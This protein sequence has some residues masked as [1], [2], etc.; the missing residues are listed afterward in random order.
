MIDHSLVP[1]HPHPRDLSLAKPLWFNVYT[2]TFPF[3]A[4]TSFRP[5]EHLHHPFPQLTTL[6]K[7]ST[8]TDR[9]VTTPRAPPL[10]IT[11]TRSPPYLACI[12][13]VHSAQHIPFFLKSL[14]AAPLCA[15][16]GGHKVKRG[17][18]ISVPSGVLCRED[19]IVGRC[20]QSSYRP[21]GRLYTRG[22]HCYHHHPRSQQTSRKEQAILHNDSCKDQMYVA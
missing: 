16:K 6:W 18:R 11:R 1:F 7:G 17:E 4:K 3:H 22:R 5:L 21:L 19:R 9:S 2:S 10:S 20:D 8:T 13:L 14:H 15:R 12:P